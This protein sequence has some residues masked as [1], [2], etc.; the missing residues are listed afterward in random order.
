MHQPWSSLK[1][2]MSLV[3]IFGR[4]FLYV[5][6]DYQFMVMAYPWALAYH[7][8]VNRLRLHQ[9]RGHD[10]RTEYLGLVLYNLLEAVVSFPLELLHI[11]DELQKIKHE[12]TDES[13]W[14]LFEVVLLI[15]LCSRRKQITS[16][17][18]GNKTHR[19]CKCGRQ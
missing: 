4:S 5:I 6:T 2:W 10:H 11:M 14:Y 9:A 1:T 15:G 18:F 8:H 13:N 16:K 17:I 7:R 3:T 12:I 19:D